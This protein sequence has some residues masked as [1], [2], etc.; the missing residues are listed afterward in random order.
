MFQ[1]VVHKGV[2][3]EIDY[4]NRYQNTKAFSISVVNSYSEDQLMH[5]CLETLQRGGRYYSQID[6]H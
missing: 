5:K 6:I 2:E 1:Q 4:I 3:S